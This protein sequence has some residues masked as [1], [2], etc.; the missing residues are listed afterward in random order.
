MVGFLPEFLIGIRMLGLPKL[1]MIIEHTADT[2]KEL[3]EKIKNTETILKQQKVIFRTIHNTKEGEKY[4]IVR[5]ESFN[6]LREKVKGKSTA[7]FIEDFCVQPENLPEFLP[8]L[9][10]ILKKNKI[11]IN[12][13]GHAGEGNLHIIPLMNLKDEKERKKIIPVAQEVYK[14]V[15]SYGGTITAEHNDG[16]IRTPFLKEMYGERMNLL[17]K[18]IKAIFDVNNIF[19]P[20]KKVG[21]TLDDVKKWMRRG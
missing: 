19:N 13:A 11:N 8:K 9:L 17:F 12:I 5:R 14:L 15:L 10:S 6:L 20:G 7:P 1:I 3:D 21:G 16:I 4:F 2:Q 18:D